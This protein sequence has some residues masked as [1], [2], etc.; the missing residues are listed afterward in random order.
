MHMLLFAAC[1]TDPGDPLDGTD[2]DD[3]VDSAGDSDT[4]EPVDTSGLELHGTAPEEEL[5]LPDF[6]A[7][8]MDGS[9]RTGV[10][11]VGHPTIVWFYPAAATGG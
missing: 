4:G 2:T 10:D 7:T 1:T 5:P 9:S 3:V 11:L 6:T 8:N